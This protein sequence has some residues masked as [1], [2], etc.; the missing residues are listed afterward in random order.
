MNFPRGVDLLLLNSGA[1]ELFTSFEFR[2]ILLALDGLSSG[3]LN[4]GL[5]ELFTSAFRSMLLP[6]DGLSSYLPAKN[7][8]TVCDI[9][10]CEID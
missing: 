5:N 10:L 7:A 2:A 1:N 6:L 8:S 3:F 4:S 9:S